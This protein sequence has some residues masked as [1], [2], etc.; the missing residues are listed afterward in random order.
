MRKY[1]RPLNRSITVGC[2]VFLL[3][4]C[5]LLSVANLTLYKNYVYDDYRGYI[6]DLL[7]Y[8]MSRIDADD[9]KIC[10]DTLTESEKYKETLLFLDDLM[11]HYDDIH[12]LYSVRPLNTNDTGSV[13]SVLSAER[14][15]DRYIDTEGNLYLGWISDDEYDSETASMLFDIMNG[16]D[17][18]YFRE[19]TEWGL[20]YTGAMPIKTSDGESIAVLAIDIDLSFINGM[21][22]NYALINIAIIAA[23]GVV[24]IGIF[25]IWSRR[26]I[27]MPIKKLQQSAVGFVGRS[28]GQRDVDALRFDAPNVKSDNEIKALS[29]AVVKMT[30]DMRD[31]VTDIISAE[32]K[33]ADLHELANRDALTGVGNKTAYDSEILRL[34]GMMSIGHTKVG[35]AIAD[36]NFLKVINDTYGH[37]KGNVALVKLCDLICDTFTHSKV[38]RIGGDE[39]VIILRGE[40]YT[41][42]DRLMESFNNKLAAMSADSSLEPWE[43]ISAAVGA[44]FYDASIDEDFD[45]LFRR[46]DH[47]MYDRKKEMKAIRS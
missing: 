4:L 43:K 41:D 26:N 45:S 23:M 34:Q 42:Y 33:A 19:E 38:F 25:L 11:E 10:I 35:L 47:V 13:L 32:R 39:F 24:F 15:Y 20:D 16:D 31:Y 40:D 27:T 14:Y 37:E 46:A 7:D 21:I 2:I 29:D 17:I 44:A 36:L 12:Y 30:Q 1:K 8:A 5:V 6:A 22:W 3:L 28:H 9:L 18:V